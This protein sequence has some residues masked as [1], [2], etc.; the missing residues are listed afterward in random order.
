[1]SRPQNNE[2]LMSLADQLVWA[3]E[4]YVKGTLDDMKGTDWSE[5]DDTLEVLGEFNSHDTKIFPAVTNLTCTLTA[6][7]DANTWGAW[8]EVT[9]SGLNT[10]TSA[11]AETSGHIT[12]ILAEDTESA[13]ERWMIEIAYGENKVRSGS[14]RFLSA[15]VGILPAIQQIRLR[16]GH[17]PA[18]ETIYARLMSSAAGSETVQIH[19]RYFLHG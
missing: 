15:S 13:G 3:I 9:D 18:G 19:I 11:F 16:S 6:H 4:E 17:I 2:N 5:T 12:A 7:A 8:T 10:L 14:M 1:M